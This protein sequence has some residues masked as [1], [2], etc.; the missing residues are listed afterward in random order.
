M[1][2]GTKSLKN[3][4]HEY[5]KRYLSQLSPSAK[6]EASCGTAQGASLSP[7]CRSRS[8]LRSMETHEPLWEAPHIA[9]MCFWLPGLVLGSSSAVLADAFPELQPDANK[10]ARFQ[11]VR[12]DAWQ[13]DEQMKSPAMGSAFSGHANAR[14]SFTFSRSAETCGFF[15]PLLHIPRSS[16]LFSSSVCQGPCFELPL[17]PR[18]IL[19]PQALY[20]PRR[21]RGFTPIPSIIFCLYPKPRVLK[22]LLRNPL[23]PFV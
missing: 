6:C 10:A 2:L 7:P 17:A 23:F 9:R 8:L 5:A 11:A 12:L 22:V 1:A 13:S 18:E 3:L 4:F 21:R 19:W 20:K 15:S 14:H 16:G